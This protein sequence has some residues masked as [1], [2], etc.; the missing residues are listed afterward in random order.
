MVIPGLAKTQKSEIGKWP[1]NNRHAWNAA[2][3]NGNWKLID[4]TWGA[5]YVK[6]RKFVKNYK[7]YFFC[8]DPEMFFF[9]HYP[10]DKKWLFTQKTEQDFVNLPLYYS[11]YQK[12][13]IKLISPRSGIIDMRQ[14]DLVLFKLQVNKKMPSLSY[15][16]NNDKYSKQLYIKHDEDEIQFSIPLENKRN[17]YLTLYDNNKAIVTY[18]LIH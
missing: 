14:S 13:N 11:N 6:S 5:G 1:K 16:F 15:A 9:K 4:V 2:K 12:S 10:S 7:E 18:K 17:R 3:I 8:S